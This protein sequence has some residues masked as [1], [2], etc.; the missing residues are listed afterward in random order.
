[1]AE[2]ACGSGGGC[3][4]EVTPYEYMWEWAPP[5]T[6]CAVPDCVTSARVT[7]SIGRPGGEMSSTLFCRPHITERAPFLDLS[8]WPN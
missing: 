4:G 8:E 1:M 3:E 7:F 6:V 5:D 2:C